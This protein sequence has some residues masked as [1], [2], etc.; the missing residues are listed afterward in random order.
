MEGTT[1]G[2]YRIDRELGAGG[3]GKVY[4]A[5][6]TRKSA[7]LAP[8]TVVALKVVHPHLLETE[9]FFKRFLLE[10]QIG[11][12]VAHENV[13]R[14][15]D[16]DA[17]G[18]SH[19]LVMEY[20]EGQTLHEL[21][22]ELHEVPEE[23]CRH[24]AREVTKGL[25]AIHAAGVVHRD[26][27]PDNVLITPDHVVK[28]MDLGVARLADEAL[29]LSQSGAFV[30]SVE[31]AA[32]EQF[33]SG[34]VDG[35]CDLHALGLVLYQLSSGVH[36]FRGE[37]FR[38][39]MRRVC[40]D[41][42]RRLGEVHPQISP[43]F[44]EVV[45]CL[46]AK[47]R[48]Q[49]F[50]SAE[51]LLSV[52]EQ[53]ED[54]SWWH[55]R[56]RALRAATRRPLRRI[57]IPRETAV[58]GR[59]DELALLRDRFD[60][61]S[62]GDGQL[63]LIQGEAGIGKSRLVDELID[64]LRRDGADLN[65]LFGSSPPGG[66]AT[67]SG[68]FTTAFREQ[69]GDAGSADYLTQTPI[70]VEAFDALLAGQRAPADAEILT[71]DSLQTC[72][73]NVTRS[74][75]AERTTVILIDDLHFAPEEGLAL[76]SALAMAVP[77]CRLL[78]IGTSRPGVDEKW[79]ADI[80]RQD[81]A[82][83]IP[84]GRLGH[85]DLA[86]LLKDSFQS[87][88]LALGL[89]GQIGIK[90]DGNPFFAFEI[91]R[92]LREGQFI[93]QT[94]E[95]TW[96]STRRIDEIQIPSSVLDLVNARVAGLTE[97]ERTLLDVAACWGYE[98]DA[99]LVG[100]VLGLASIPTLRGFGQIER[101][102]RLVRSAGRSY[103]FDHHQVQEALY[104]SMNIQLREEYHAAL[105]DALETRTGAADGDPDALDGVL[106]VS[107]CEHFL[108]GA[109]G[110]RAG[111][112]L[113]PA[114][115]H[116]SESYS[117]AHV[118]ALARRALDVDGLLE[119]AERA[120]TLLRRATALG[121]M[122]RREQQEASAREAERLA[123]EAGD[124]VL[125]G[126][127]LMTL[128]AVLH[129]T[130]RMEESAAA[131]QHALELARSCGD[132]SEESAATNN[133]GNVLCYQGHLDEAREHYDAALALSR[134]IDDRGGEARASGNKGF[135][136]RMQGRLEEARELHQLQLDISLEQGN[137]QSEALV[138]GNLGIVARS[139]GLIYESREYH[140]RHLAISREI[141]SR[142]GETLALANLASASFALGRMDHARDGYDASL[143]VAR[144]IGDRYS[145]GYAL[146]GLAGVAHEQDDAAAALAHAEA[147]LAI[148]RR[149][150]Q[151]DG[152][153]DSLIQVGHLLLN[154][155]RD[156]R[157]RAVLEEAVPLAREQGRAA[158][159]IL[160]LVFL[161]RLPDGRA[162]EALHALEVAGANGDSTI[163]RLHLWRATG[164]R[165]HLEVARRLLDESLALIPAEHH[166]AIL[167]N[168]RT[169]R[170][171]MAAWTA[172]F[173][174]DGGSGPAE[175]ETRAG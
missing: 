62:T 52:L 111:R 6:L 59:E 14:T 31:Y 131:F 23:L 102:H 123:A 94:A 10:A 154:A 158:Q 16:C 164:D 167:A 86:E 61:A 51:A 104:G 63:V 70:L 74:L 26:L 126:R 146:A 145:Q 117:N 148:R 139:Q 175:S 43:F 75:A 142:A 55:E 78:L 28:V 132:V 69:L 161:A 15:L 159:H 121:R 137:R 12:S 128:G 110:E 35:R 96:I 151:R 115:A 122:G 166:E 8:D 56:K 22:R 25:V 113:T 101:M 4:G 42:P 45:H 81:H 27:K 152:I 11:R 40:H 66:A 130:S 162:D 109:R 98:F 133:I 170:E 37:D 140:E 157:A 168:C 73:M 105:A 58:Y 7:G 97:D 99:R 9:G 71:K 77:G 46:L 17:I 72:F 143:R 93:T 138:L 144:E 82:S 3:M 120:K 92:G 67:A 57:R 89:A 54:S 119:G 116:L 136:C 163:I 171:M 39:V 114:L 53:G 103:V 106:S 91:I 76:F 64:R 50:A 65:F 2:P 129:Q 44:E 38:T 127:A 84:L 79:L 5:T 134:S 174:G 29:R 125:R 149:I 160:A 88:Q 135:V 20:V 41:Q 95:G 85:R 150:G 124:D 107:L 1:L 34:D 108:A 112:Y 36:P 49:R 68:A 100:E 153:A 141:G 80:T 18:G 87:E 172:E 155:G 147:A 32:P 19:F 156:D 24:I 60:R 165:T 30:G 83:R 33:G 118:D 13:V 47:D 173:E 48:D 169:D 90:S 21:Q